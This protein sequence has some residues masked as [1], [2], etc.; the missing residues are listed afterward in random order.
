VI[1]LPQ[2]RAAQSLARVELRNISVLGSIDVEQENGDHFLLV[3]L[4]RAMPI[5][6]HLPKTLFGVPVKSK[7]LS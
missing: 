6:E 7:V 2:A 1:T 3:T 5:N 4:S